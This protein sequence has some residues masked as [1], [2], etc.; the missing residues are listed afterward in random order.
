MLAGDDGPT[1]IHR[2]QQRRVPVI[3]TWAGE[4]QPTVRLLWTED[5]EEQS[6]EVHVG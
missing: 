1:I 3:M 5:G 6:K 2:G 4:G